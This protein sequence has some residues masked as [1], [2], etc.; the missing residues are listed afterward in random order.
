MFNSSLDSN[1][2]NDIFSQNG[3]YN[4]INEY[5][6]VFNPL[7]ENPNN[8]HESR[9]ENQNSN[10]LS[11]ANNYNSINNNESNSE[12][13]IEISNDKISKDNSFLKYVN[14]SEDNLININKSF[15]DLEK[16]KFI[17][18]LKNN[19]YIK[20]NYFFLEEDNLINKDKKKYEENMYNIMN[21]LKCKG[22]FQ[23]PNEF[24]ICSLNNTIL[25]ENCLGREDEKNK[26]YKLCISCNSLVTSNDHFIKLPILNKIISYINKTKE[27]NEKLFDFRIKEFLDKNIIL[28]SDDIHNIINKEDFLININDIKNDELMIKAVY[29]CMECLKPFC[30]DCILNY[31][32]KHKK[33]PNKNII[34]DLEKDNDINEKHNFSHPIFKIDLLKDI[35]VFDLLYEKD[36][37][38]KIIEELSSFDKSINDKIEYL[39]NN[40][41][42][43]ILFFDYIKNIYIEIVDEIII[44]LKNIAQEKKEKIE[45]IKD[46]SQELSNFLNSIKIKKDLKN[47]DNIKYIK[48]LLNDLNSF[49]KIP[50]EIKKKARKFIKFKGAFNLE[51]LSDFTLDF[52]INKSLK[53]K[54][55]NK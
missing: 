18:Y 13:E 48:Q 14:E 36:K 17:L 37:C 50:Y 33:N 31:K 38:Q 26:D 29:F 40:K 53:K 24:F 4:A 51:E 46:K 30:S 11:S 49:H 3:N 8:Y 16:N 35:G 39:D 45:I 10:L 9:T 27:N 41:K 28:C 7:L 19:N 6:P 12:N 20:N 22:C 2:P 34:N 55:I 47:S 54:I 43:I 32:L 52:N 15:K 21:K 23:L 1:N 25:C 5:I 42:N 44:D